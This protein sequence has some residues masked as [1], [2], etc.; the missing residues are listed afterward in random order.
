MQITLKKGDIN[1]IL[2]FI[3]ELNL[4]GSKLN[5]ARFRF[6]ELLKLKA[7]EVNDERLEIAKSYSK[8]DSN[9][10]PK[11]VNDGNLDIPQE[12]IQA[13]NNAQ[14][15][16]FNEK[17]SLTVDDYKEPLKLLFTKLNNYDG[18]LQGTDLIA[19][20]T[21]L[22]AMEQAG[23]IEDLEKQNDFKNY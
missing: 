10:Y 15:E 20:G 11:T 2:K 8:L 23:F 22:D 21:I 13:F 17:C 18:S 9:G 16:M 19:Y 4:A 5:R 3:N 7:K 12:K 14:M 1:A 6:I